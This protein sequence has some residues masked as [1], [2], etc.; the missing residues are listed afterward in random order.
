MPKEKPLLLIVL[1]LIFIIPLLLLGVCILFIP[2]LF[3]SI[4]LDYEFNDY[5]QTNHNLSKNNLD[6]L[7]CDN[8]FKKEKIIFLFIDSLPFDTELFS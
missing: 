7:V 4:N 3:E 8:K 1:K 2:E 6:Y 5:C